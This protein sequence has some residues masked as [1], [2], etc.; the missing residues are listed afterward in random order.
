MSRV[1]CQNVTH[2]I[3]VIVAPDW[4]LVCSRIQSGSRH[5]RSADHQTTGSDAFC[6]YTTRGCCCHGSYRPPKWSCSNSATLVANRI[7]RPLSITGATSGE[8]IRRAAVSCA[9]SGVKRGVPAQT[10]P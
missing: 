8:P 10:A 6:R 3:Q 7:L 2:G 4:L 9:H 1:I 5:S